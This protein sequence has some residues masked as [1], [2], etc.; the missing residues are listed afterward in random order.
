M[1]KS[2]SFKLLCQIIRKNHHYGGWYI[3][4]LVILSSFFYLVNYTM[5][6][7]L[8][9]GLNYLVRSHG[10]EFY[11]LGVSNLPMQCMDIV[12]MLLVMFRVA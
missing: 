3:Q 1:L 2:N 8:S 4:E 12:I 11:V 10:F 9:N 6:L 7:V 5:S